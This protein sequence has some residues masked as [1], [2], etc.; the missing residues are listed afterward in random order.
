VDLLVLLLTA[1]YGNYFP[2]RYIMLDGSS[3]RVCYICHNFAVYSLK[4]IKMKR[5]RRKFLTQVVTAGAGIS[6]AGL[7]M[8]QARG[9]RR[10]DYRH[11]EPSLLGKKVLYIHGGWEGHQPEQSVDLFVPWMREEGAEV[12]VSGSLDSYLDQ[13]LMGGLDLVVQIWT[14]GKITTEQEKGLLEAVKRGTG[15]AGWH[16]GIGDSFRDN[17]EYQFMVGGQWVSHPGGV[18]DYKVNIVDRDDPVTKGLGDFA[19]HSE[20]YYMHVDPN[21]KVLATTRFSG[22][23]AHWI[24]GCTMPVVWKKYYGNGRVFYSSLGHVMKDFEVLQALEI[25]KRGIRWAS[26]SKYHPR[27]EWRNPV[28]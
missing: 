12:V 18:I 24:E 21:I 28:Y 3:N 23:H 7:G 20:Q 9:T 22:D 13:D 26:E 1:L 25:Q 11:I 2:R 5:T 8:A 17:V 27:E 19:M 14:M 6:L 10:D 15:I 16:G 4:S